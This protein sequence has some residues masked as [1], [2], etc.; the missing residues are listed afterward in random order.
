MKK[1]IEAHHLCF[2]IRSA[3]LG[4]P[5]HPSIHRVDFNES[6][7]C[8]CFDSGFLQLRSN[9]LLMDY[10]VTWCFGG[11]TTTKKTEKMKMKLVCERMSK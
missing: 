6:S 1:T 5:Y 3:R 4:S 8:C 9:L 10:Y 7:C 2:S 11:T